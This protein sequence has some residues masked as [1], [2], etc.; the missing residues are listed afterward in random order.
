[1]KL[2]KYELEM[3]EGKHG[4]AKREAI[5]RLI[6]FGEAVGAEEMVPIVSAHIFAPD[7]TMGRIPKYDYGTAP[8]YREFAELGAEVSVLTTTDPCFMQIDKFS[9]EGYPWNFRGVQL[10]RDC[11]DGMIEGA[12]LLGKMGIINTFSCIPYLNL[13]IPKYGDYYAWCEGNAACYANTICGSK[14]NRENSIT[15]FYAAIAGVHPRHGLM[16]DENRR[17]QILCE[18]HQRVLENLRTIADWNAL[19]AFLGMKAYDKI[20]VVTGLSRI[21]IEQAKA[22][23]ATASP[24]LNFPKLNLVGISP[25]SPT[26]EAAFGGAIPRG[27]EK[28]EITV[29]DIQAIYETLNNAEDDDVDIVVTGCPFL[30]LNEVR[31]VA[32]KLSGKK[33]S[34]NVAFWVQTDIHTYLMADLLGL[35]AM[36]EKA[37]AKIYHDTCMGNG[38]AEKWGKVNIGTDSFKNIKLFGGRGQKFMFGTLDDLI[39]AGVSGKFEPTRWGK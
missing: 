26:I 32:M 23:S 5:E 24:A 37:G 34:G 20:P 28:V 9:E 27:V 18:L 1:M 10:P 8:I 22:L 21:S 38:P 2:S 25:D 3:L 15:A 14:T 35:T 6:K 4:E 17:G 36:I 16:C 39:S 11:R 19:G 30:N 33:I 12:D 31:D 7:A 29:R 13:N